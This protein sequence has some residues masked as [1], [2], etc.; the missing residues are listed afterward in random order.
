M[1]N[2]TQ[3]DIG[4]NR[5]VPDILAHIKKTKEIFM[6]TNGL[7]EQ[8]FKSADL[9]LAYI[10]HYFSIDTVSAA[11]FA[12]LA[13]LYHGG[14]TEMWKLADYLHLDCLDMIGYMDSLEVLA[15]KE[16]ICIHRDNTEFFNP[17]FEEQISFVVKLT[18]IEA[19]SKGNYHDLVSTKNLSIGKFFTYIEQICIDRIQR[20]RSYQK[21]LSAM[22]NLLC[23]NEHLALVQKLKKLTLS[24]EDTFILF[25]F[26][27]YT[28][29]LDESEMTNRHLAA[30]YDYGFEFAPI[31]RQ[32]KNGNHVLMKKGIIE[33][34]WGNGFNDANSFRL[35]DK[36]KEEF[37]SEL[38]V[39]PS[40]M[41]IDG[42][43]S[44]ESI[45]LKLLFY[46]EKTQK[47]I[48]E[49]TML[50]QPDSFR[51]VQSRLFANGMRTGFA[52]LFSGS[53][54]TGKTETACQI[55]RA[56][57]R[58][59]MQVNIAEIK[60][61][62]F[63]ESEKQIKALFN[64]YRA[65]VERC[66][67]TPILLFNEADAIIGNGSFWTNTRTGQGRRKTPCKTSSWKRSKT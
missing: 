19:I 28:V 34:G 48:D 42:L 11:L 46:P 23:D 30:L 32:L 54:G 2:R 6:Q 8:F 31:R 65:C 25:L 4:Q 33:Y 10:G 60:S 14:S 37:L 57:G 59:I 45:L 15:A 55:A 61:K 1:D 36:A 18:A 51:E 3:N 39:L 47:A 52:C 35:T 24:D 66:E 22:K 26:F 7:N 44:V 20:R 64:K 9:H 56:C 40:E 67:T 12:A 5:K 49:L 29:D 27:Y 17:A 21:T 53:P 58:D 63:G 50:L 62:W 43:K 38:D 41:Y 16:L 13:H